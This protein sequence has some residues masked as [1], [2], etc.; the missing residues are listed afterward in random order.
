MSIPHRALLPLAYDAAVDSQTGGCLRTAS[1]SSLP[2]TCM[3][4]SGVCINAEQQH[5][6]DAAPSM[7]SGSQAL[8]NA[9]EQLRRERKDKV[10]VAPSVSD[11]HCMLVLSLNHTQVCSHS[12]F[13]LTPMLKLHQLC[14]SFIV[15]AVMCRASNCGAH[16]NCDEPCW[17]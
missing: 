5:Q 16:N 8:P 6:S 13:L 1:T 9:K 14:W 12:R 7:D 15:H 2:C 11:T 17:L 3:C 4:T 10:L